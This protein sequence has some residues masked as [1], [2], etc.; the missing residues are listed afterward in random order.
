MSDNCV[1]RVVAKYTPDSSYSRHSEGSFI[2][3]NDG[4]IMFAYSRFTGNW[5]DDAP[6]NIV[7]VYSSDEGETWSDAEVLIYA[8]QYNTNNVMSVSLL[9]MANGDLGLFYIVKQTMTENRLILSRS[10][11]DG[12]TFYTHIECSLP[13][14]KG[15][16]VLNNDRVHVTPTGRILVP[17]AFHRGG[18]TSGT[19]AYFDGRGIGY[20][21]YSDD[22]GFSWDEAPGN[23]YPTFTGS[24]TGLQEPGVMDMPGGVLWVYYRTD[25]M[26]QYEAF[27][28]DD[29]MHW[30][31]AQPSK[32]T[33][34]PSPLKVARNSYDGKLYAVWNPVPNYNGRY[35]AK[36][37]WGRTPLV[38]AVS[39]GDGR[40]FGAYKVIEDGPENG[41]C[42]P[43]VFFTGDGGMLVAYC[44]GGPDERACLAQLTMKKITL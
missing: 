39:E 23:V 35:I 29:G 24:N 11:D 41:Y 17:L 16:Y 5:Q 10:K 42:Y 9:R 14:R 1:G 26:L 2:R 20:F 40:D 38:Y 32:F 31:V 25:M 7:A 3:L 28:L 27:S 30:T 4:R 22:D 6:S 44:S 12:K 43:A 34:P 15:Y 8:S 33:S 21:L 18:H 37:G 13:D 36:A 19:G